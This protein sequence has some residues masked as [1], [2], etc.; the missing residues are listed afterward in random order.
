[1]SQPILPML[2]AAA[3]SNA[4]LVT[5][6]LYTLAV[7]ALAWFSNRLLQSKNFISEYFLGSRGLGMWAFALTFAATSSSGGSFTGFP[8]KIYTH[9]WI[10]ALWIASY[11]VVPICAMGLLGKRINQVARI[12][13]SITVPDVIRDRFHSAAFGLLAT[14][15]IVFFMSFN[16]VAQFKAGSKI[17]QTLIEDVPS[18]QAAT[19]WL[20]PRVQDV[21]MLQGVDP[22]YLLCLVAFALAVVAYTTYGGFHAVVWT[23]VMQGIVML[24]G[25][26][27]MLPL[28]VYM[29]GG[30]STVTSQMA[31]MIPPE[32][33]LADLTVEPNLTAERPYVISVGDWFTASR[34]Q[35]TLR[36]QNEIERLRRERPESSAAQVER[37]GRE[38]PEGFEDEIERLRRLRFGGFQPRIEQ[39]QKR[40][41]RVKEGPS[42]LLFRVVEPAV[43]PIG[44]TTARNVEVLEIRTPEEIAM[45]RLRIERAA[46]AEDSSRAGEISQQIADLRQSGAA[47]RRLRPSK[48]R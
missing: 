35:E 13:G 11:M 8:A 48:G 41:S 19:T 7:F 16:L 30:L 21:G 39:A 42:V 26:V 24:A 28:A 34:E 37:L 27:I 14:L 23:D 43:I 5:F 40:L 46:L 47:P 10:L 9:G 12:S 4:A 31:R 45:Q 1:M 6:L 22:G 36:V 2:L 25:V 38:R 29:A 17:L 20:A 3:Q 15:L 32:P 44:E 18:F 33:A